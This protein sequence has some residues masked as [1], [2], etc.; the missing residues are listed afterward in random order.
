MTP[1]FDFTINVGGVVAV[2]GIVITIIKLHASNVSRMA[3]M[4]TKLD[5]LF[6]WW[7][8]RDDQRR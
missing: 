5:I 1:A 8:G 4:E 3:R 6:S 2:L 7:S